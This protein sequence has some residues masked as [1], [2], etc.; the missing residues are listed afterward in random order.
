M[1]LMDQSN[2][3]GRKFERGYLANSRELRR[4]RTRAKLPLKALAK[5]AGVNYT[6][7]SRIENRHNRSPHWSTLEQIADALGVD[8]EEIVIFLDEPNN[9]AVTD[10]NR[11]YGE[12]AIAE[13]KERYRAQGEEPNR[14][15]DS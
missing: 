14:I 15:E 8:V 11:A 9:G 6:T 7:I 13:E 10:E 5:K 1:L 12:R 2:E 4:L 3:T